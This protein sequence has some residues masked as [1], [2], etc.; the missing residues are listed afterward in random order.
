MKL[1]RTVLQQAG[2]TKAKLDHIGVFRRTIRNQKGTITRPLDF[3]PT[4]YAIP[5]FHFIV[6]N[7]AEKYVHM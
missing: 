2:K 5:P 1:Y 7:A 6:L 4:I 3:R